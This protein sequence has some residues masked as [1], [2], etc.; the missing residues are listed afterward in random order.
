[1]QTYDAIIIGAGQAAIPLAFALASKGKHVALVEKDTVG[2]SCVNTGCTPTKAYV[3][4][5]KRIH[6][7]R[8]AAQ[9]G[10]SIPAGVKADLAEIK[11]RKDKLVQ[12]SVE[13]LITSLK[14]NKRIDLIEGTA[15]FVSPERLAVDGREIEGDFIFIN[16]GARPRV[17]SG[18]ENVDVLTNTEILQLEELPEHL[19]VVGG[20]YVG[21]EFGQMFRRFG[22]RV[23]I[24]EKSDR[25]IGRED[26]DVSAAIKEILEQEDIDFR[27]NANCIAASRGVQGDIQLQVDCADAMEEVSGSHVLLAAGRIPNTDTLQIEQAGV[28]I[29]DQGYIRVNDTLETNVPGIYALGDCNGKGA[30][31][32]T[33][34]NDYEIVSENLLQ[35]GNRKVSDRI[36]TYGL[37]IDPPLGRAG[38]TL[39]EARL[40]G[41]NIR[42]GY[43]KMDKVARARERGE[44]NGF[45]RVIVDAYTH[46]ILGASILGAGGDELISGILT[47]MYSGAP[48]TV[49]K[50]AVV[51]HPTVAELIPTMLESMEEVI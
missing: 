37:Y 17:P 40:S 23:T 24:V 3:A 8:N 9:L 5:A 4:S 6:D 51:P 25:L 14:K 18:F 35:G 50:D 16:V 45:M 20:S 12:S 28:E 44:T 33:S 13:G 31:T 27:M 42:V 36:L 19:L 15:S 26:E 48:Y 11:R 46:R 49:I 7:A 30:F 41:R 10:I 43:M 1:M 39:T 38:M 32:H 2:G 22:S 21:L 34:Y 47:A 29:D